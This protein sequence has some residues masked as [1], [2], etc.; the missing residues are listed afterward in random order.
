LALN[1]VKDEK[2][3]ELLITLT[4]QYE[5]PPVAGSYIMLDHGR[6]QK[7]NTKGADQISCSILK[8]S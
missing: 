5:R 8:F 7:Q 1:I 4:D 6:A 3:V 2:T